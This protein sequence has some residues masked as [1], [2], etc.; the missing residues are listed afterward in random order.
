[1]A[2]YWFLL[3]ATLSEP[4]VLL[5]GLHD[6]FHEASAFE[7]ARHVVAD[8]PLLPKRPDQCVDAAKRPFGSMHRGYAQRT[9]M[10]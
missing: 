1:M 9:D 2:S 4:Y 6:V 10:R 7:D 3:A 5:V 8:C